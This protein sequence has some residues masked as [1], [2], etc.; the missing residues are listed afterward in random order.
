MTLYLLM[1]L[2]HDLILSLKYGEKL[3]KFSVLSYAC[4]Q[5]A[6]EAR[7]RGE[8]DRISVP[9]TKQFK[10]LYCVFQ[11]DGRLDDM[12]HRIQVEWMKRKEA[13]EVLRDKKIR[14]K[15]K[16]KFYRAI[17]RLA[18]LYGS[19]CWAPTGQHLHK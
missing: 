8:L 16:Y 4:V 3:L 2:M 12:T 7:T 10:Y 6:E 1:K 18:M 14:L 17:V 9:N 11:N 5:S 13:S 15:I 19:E